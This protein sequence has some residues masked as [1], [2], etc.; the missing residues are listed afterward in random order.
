MSNGVFKSSS[1]A[2]GSGLAAL[3]QAAKEIDTARAELDAAY[4]RLQGQWQSS[5][6]RARADA[7]YA[8]VMQ[9]LE[10]SVAWARS[11]G[12]T[13]EEANG[14]FAKVESAGVA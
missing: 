9:W 6:A 2:M 4:R 7:E 14:M 13:T 12:R 10:S 5:E 1:V 3:E 11:C 8:K